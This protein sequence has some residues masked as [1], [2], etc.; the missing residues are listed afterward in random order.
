MNRLPVQDARRCAWLPCSRTFTPKPGATNARYHSPACKR[1]A[2]LQQQRDWCAAHR[3]RHREHRF[4]QTP[5]P[6]NVA[7]D[8]VE[9]LMKWDLADP[10]D[11]PARLGRILRRLTRTHGGQFADIVRWALTERAQRRQALRRM[12]NCVP[13]AK[14]LPFTA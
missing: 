10:A 2:H 9:R 3:D 6:F 4:D 1:L 8:A 7:T 12:P 13:R 14:V 11:W 5:H